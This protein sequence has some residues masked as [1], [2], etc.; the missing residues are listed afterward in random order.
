M[1]ILNRSGDVEDLWVNISLVVLQDWPWSE[2]SMFLWM[3]A[4]SWISLGIKFFFQSFVKD[5]SVH[6]VKGAFE[7]NKEEKLGLGTFPALPVLIVVT[8]E[9]KQVVA[10]VISF[11]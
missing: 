7:V 3:N 4:R 1:A 11:N 5:F 9:A 8:G 10:G 6:K 2:M